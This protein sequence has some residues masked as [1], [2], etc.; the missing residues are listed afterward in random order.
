LNAIARIFN[1]H[2]MLNSGFDNFLKPLV[3]ALCPLAYTPA[4]Q[5]FDKRR[6]HILVQMF[7]TNFHRHQ[8]A[9]CAGLVGIGD[10]P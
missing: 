5:V 2:I 1:H 10:R 7:R 3:D 6:R 4:L 8:R 9:R